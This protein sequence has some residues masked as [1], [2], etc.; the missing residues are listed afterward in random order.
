MIEG[1]VTCEQLNVIHLKKFK[2]TRKENKPTKKD[3]QATLE[4]SDLR[5][6]QRPEESRS[7]EIG[8]RPR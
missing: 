7:S 1:P 5:G 4:N 8:F 2:K 3:D 6:Q